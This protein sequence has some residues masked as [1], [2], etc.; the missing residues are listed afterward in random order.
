MAPYIVLVEDPRRMIIASR[1]SYA[2]RV[3]AF[4]FCHILV[5]A[6]AYRWSPE[7]VDL[8]GLVDT[9]ISERCGTLIVPGCENVPIHLATSFFCRSLLQKNH[10]VVIVNRFHFQNSVALRMDI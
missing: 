5:F 10:E 7:I 8:W 4:L 6:F 2:R 1:M 9:S 3:G